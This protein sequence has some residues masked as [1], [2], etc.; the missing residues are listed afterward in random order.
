MKQLN[1]F[2]RSIFTLVF[3]LAFFLMFFSCENSDPMSA[4]NSTAEIT[5]NASQTGQTV[6]GKT[7]NFISLGTMDNQGLN[8]SVA[9]EKFIVKSKGGSMAMEYQSTNGKVQA[10][11]YLSVPKNAIDY[12]KWIS[13]TFDDQNNAGITDIVFGPHGT[14]Y[15]SPAL[16]SL[17]AVGLDLSGVDPNNVKLYYVNE[18]G[19]WDVMV[20]DKII[21]DPSAGFVYVSNAQLPH[22]SRYALAAD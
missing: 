7:L 18:N 15:S 2:S 5:A 11:F 16:L 1:V 21:V 19:L 13:M 8:K 22:F 12:S 3:S 20:C 6:D 17:K 4:N 9:T 14:Q 10:A